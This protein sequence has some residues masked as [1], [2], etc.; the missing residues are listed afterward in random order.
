M[1]QKP[2]LSEFSYQELLNYIS[3]QKDVDGLTEENKK[4]WALG[5]GLVPCTARSVLKILEAYKISLEN[6]EIVILG[7]SDLSGKPLYEILKE[8]NKVV[9]C[10]SKTKEIKKRIKK[11]DIVITAI[12]R[13]HYLTKDYFNDGQVIIDVGTS[14]LEGRLVGDVNIETLE[15]LEVKVTKVPGGVGQLTPIFLFDN[16][17]L[18]HK[19]M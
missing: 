14:Y 18:A 1:I 17:L 11:A 2:I 13:P 3:P 15:S 16:L 4:K 8:K 12:G 5:S 9:L 19:K 6:K 7:K 10:D